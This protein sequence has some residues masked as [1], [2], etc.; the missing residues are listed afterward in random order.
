M[1]SEN[2]LDMGNI[3]RDEEYYNQANA[4]CKA[5]DIKE[6]LFS[7]DISSVENA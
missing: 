7:G 4:E 2:K 6:N 5:A 1:K 3:W